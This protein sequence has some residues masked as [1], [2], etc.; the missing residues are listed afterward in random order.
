MV[1]MLGVNGV[2]AQ[3]TIASQDFETSPATP[4]MT[5]SE[6]GSGGTAG[7]ISGNS[8]SGDRPAS[9][10]YA[11]GGS[12]AYGVLNTSRTL[13]FSAVNTSSYSTIVFTCRLA[14]WSISSTGNGADGSDNVLVEVSPDN[15]TTW[16][17][18]VLVEG[19][20]N[21]YWSYGATGNASNT[22]AADNTSSDY[23][24][25]GGGSRSTDGYST[26]TISSLPAVTQLRIRIS[27]LNNASSERWTIDDA[28]ISGT[29]AASAP[30]LTT[31][32]VSLITTTTATLG[33]TITANGGA[34]ISS[35][36]TVWGTTA[37]PTGNAVA[38]GGTA[39]SAF[40]HGRTGFTANTLY[41][42][43]GYAINTNG[44]GYSPDGT[45]TTLSLAPTIGTGSGAAQT[46]FTANWSA[47]AS[48]GA[49]TFTYSIDVDDDINFGSINF[50]QSSIASGTITANVNS[51]L[52]AGTTYY[53]RVRAVNAGGN[54]DWSATSAGIAT[55]AATAPVITTPT[56][57]SIVN[58]TA[59]LGGNV[60][61]DGG[62]AITA[63]G[64]VWSVDATNSNPTIGGIGTTNVVGSGTTGVFTV[65][66]TGLSPNTLIA[67]RAY[68]TNSVGT[69]YTTATTFTTLS[70][71]TK[72]VFGTAPIGTGNVG[73]NLTT[74]TVQA[75]R[76]D[77]SVDAEY[78]TNVAI[79]RNIVSGTAALTGTTSVTP[80]SGTATFS[81]AQ[82][83]AVG[84][85]T[86]TASS[87]ALTTTTSG[88]IV[89]SVANSTVNDWINTSSTTA[90]CTG[91][92]WNTGSVPTSAQVAQFNNTGSA[93][94]AGVT[95]S[96]CTPSILGIEMSSSRTRD[97]TIGGTGS[98]DGVITLN[99]GIINS[100]SN[101]ILRNASSN[102]LTI[103]PNN[104][105]SAILGIALANATTNTVN[106]NG[107][108]NIVISSIISGSSIQLTLNT[109]S[110]GDLRLSGANTYSGGTIINSSSTGRLRID[111]TNSLPS[112]GTVRI[113]TAG[114]LRF[115]V[116]GTYGGA[117]QALEFNPNQTANP[118]LDLG[119]TGSATWQGT[120]NLIA[121]ARIEPTNSGS[122]L[123]FSG[124][125]TGAG[126]LVK[127]AAGNLVLSG[128]SNNLT[129]G[130]QIGNGTL[131]VNSG[132]SMGTGALLMTQTAGNNTALTLNENQTVSSLSSS[133]ADATGTRTQV[134]T[135]ANTK[136]LTVNQSTNTT[137]GTGAV[138]TLTS[139]ITGA[140]GLTK[141]G[142][143]T[144]TLTSAN[145]YTGSTTINGGSL[146]MGIANALS[147]TPII[148]NGGTLSSG[149]ST[150]F[151][152]TVSTIQ[153]TENSTLNLG[154]GN[155]TVTFAASNSIVWTA[156]KTLTIYGW[157]GG[158]NGTAATGSNPKLIVGSSASGLTTAQLEQIV[159]NNG[160]TNFA[161]TILSNGEVVPTTFSASYYYQGGTNGMNE[162]TNWTTG[163]TGTGNSPSSFDA[164]DQTFNIITNVS[165]VDNSGTFTV[166]GSGSKIVLGNAGYG[167]RTLTIASG[168]PINATIDI[169]APGGGSGNTLVI[170]DATAPTLG[171][172]AATANVTYNAAADQNIQVKSYRNLTLGGS[173]VKTLTGA[174]GVTGTLT[175]PSGVTLDFGN[176][177]VSGT[178]GLIDVQSGATV[179]TAQASGLNGSNTTTGVSSYSTGA[180]YS[181]NGS[182]SQVFG[183]YMPNTVN[184]LTINNGNTNMLL[185]ASRT[186]NGTLAITSGKLAIGAS[187]TLTLNGGLTCDATNSLISTAT[188]NITLTGAAK[189][190]YFDASNNNLRNLAI[191]GSNTMTLGNTLNITGGTSFGVV[192]VGTGATLA[193]GGFL[194]LKSTDLGTAS[195]GTS[196]GAVT[197]SVTVERFVSGSGRRWRFLSSPV[198]SATVANWM[199]QFYVTG[200]CTVAPVGGLGSINDQGWHTSQA[201]I[202][203]PGAYNISTNNRAVR[204]TSI[205]TY[206]E[207]AAGNNT[208]L[209]AGWADLTGTSQAL[210]PGQGFRTFV[211]GPIGTT[212]QLDGSVTSQT[213]VTLSLNG[214]V[215]QG[216]VTPTLTNNTQGWNLL[217]NPYACGYDFNAQ[218]DAS[219]GI[220]NIDPTVYVYDAV[221]N[222]YVSYNASSNTPGGLAS[223]VIPSA[224]GF[225]VRATG[226]PTFQ[227]R[228][229]YKTIAVN[230]TAVHKTEIS[231]VD[232]GI[233][234]FKDSTESDY[235]VVKM[236]EGATMNSELFDIKK[237]Y[238]ENLNLSAY[239]VDTIQLTA[240]CIPFITGETKVKLNVEA[241]QVGTYHFDF[242]NMDNF[243]SNVTV[244]LFD[245]FTN[246]TTDVRKNTKYTFV[247]DAGVNQWGKNRFELILNL[248]KTNVDEFA[249]LNQTHMLVYPNPA[250]DVLNININNSSFK[251][252]E[253]VVYNIS[254][255]EVLKTNMAANNAQLNIETLSNGVYFV[256]V[257]NQNGFNKTVKFVK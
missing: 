179:I 192:T 197:G 145:T 168:K 159:F 112:T 166:S 113:N 158:Y 256:K 196:L 97:L 151:S 5:Y 109:T 201:N 96:N 6:S 56:S 148:L 46:S 25:A 255:T 101:T 120:V 172:L 143:G 13:T 213:E 74:F 254:G 4:T 53:Y 209:N 215:N 89:V 194:T 118:A 83:D 66:V 21:A 90:W 247:M 10:A 45:F 119:F 252:S 210:T 216:T 185:G 242:K 230:P 86:I 115:N 87:A 160:S 246:T 8:A 94:Q 38:E 42:Y 60:N 219:Q 138:S 95:F 54:S 40:T 126:T 91:S 35:R 41:T 240:S 244:S 234:Y 63:R 36:G 9:T 173:G 47:P 64:V 111:A 133:F 98:T 171:T 82:F 206:N 249:L 211:R 30:I 224:A 157:V 29:L 199:T 253:V 122:T 187:N 110:S 88:N 231:T 154:T 2:L 208:N 163:A 229:D 39:V 165:T 149:A 19:N 81:A 57:A 186:I 67:Y 17:D 178:N 108:G 28:N 137:Y 144:L 7:V 182:S 77:N 161:A 223:G 100:I 191:T 250:T 55:L 22:Y 37:T 131:T 170:S 116:T 212:G 174:T 155:H 72:L 232:F 27:L 76:A 221:T 70:V 58:T 203:Y 202:D 190:L 132:S 14:S 257:S 139:T 237:V 80:V 16:Y 141:S 205:R 220:T 248:D 156:G 32:S 233:K 140:G 71:A 136:A 236:F 106:I 52:S 245:R 123:T 84:T 3:T 127:A 167:S 214:T 129:G 175:V 59:I 93:T 128:T 69:T 152:Q 20:S 61:G 44:T 23:A 181:F 142:A 183:A 184:N 79:T 227:F 11:S 117:S 12:R 15:G 169:V 49:A 26:I 31:P 147:S 107:T 235:M 99:G 135:V 134:I 207:S 33:A 65:N 243:Q 18:R 114:A 34:A 103:Q 130:T 104:T 62:A 48:Q 200:P 188:S 222:G 225:F 251:N 153:V 50:T 24:P 180:S 105:N 217:G 102:T 177:V 68:A 189:T 43:R 51:G 146:I 228:E 73:V 75:Q 150:G 78:T 195:I 226:A 238:N 121:D 92:N 1:L 218:Y 124:N 204:T 176:N 241:S 125:A 198:T 85:Y 239:G 164:A 162:L 193:T